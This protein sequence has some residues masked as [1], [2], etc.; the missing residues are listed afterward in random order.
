MPGTLSYDIE[1]LRLTSARIGHLMGV[2]DGIFQKLYDQM[3]TLINAQSLG[4]SPGAQTA[5][6]RYNDQQ[7]K[8]LHEI[9]ALKIDHMAHSKFVI[10]EAIQDMPAA[11]EEAGHG[12][13]KG[14]SAPAR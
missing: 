13:T 4:I 2:I 8:L 14:V 9:Y 11:S 5:E 10:D 1:Q 12:F 6:H 7:E 3:T